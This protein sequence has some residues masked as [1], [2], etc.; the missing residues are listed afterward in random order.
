MR[1][2]KQFAGNIK[3]IAA[4]TVGVIVCAFCFELVGHG[5]AEIPT[6]TARLDYWNGMT[7]NGTDRCP[8]EAPKG[9]QVVDVR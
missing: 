4:F 8:G 9:V 3:A 6:Y 5:P 2:D 7:S 1:E